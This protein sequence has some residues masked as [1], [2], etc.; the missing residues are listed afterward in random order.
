MGDRYI[1]SRT[2]HIQ[3]MTDNAYLIRLTNPASQNALFRAILA[4][5]FN[6][7]NQGEKNTVLSLVINPEAKNLMLSLISDLKGKP[8]ERILIDRHI[9]ACAT[10]FDFAGRRG[11]NV[12]CRIS[13][14]TLARSE[15]VSIV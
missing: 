11:K 8:I 12:Q 9:E 14:R 7:R 15:R 4:S 5:A 10:R 1:L 6:L 2:L 3:N 13:C